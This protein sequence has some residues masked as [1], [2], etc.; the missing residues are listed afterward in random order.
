[1]A[2]WKSLPTSGRTFLRLTAGDRREF[3]LASLLLPT[4]ALAFRGLGFRRWQATLERWA[5]RSATV[6]SDADATAKGLRTAWLVR[7]AARF[8]AGRE[9]CLAQALVLW[10]LLRRRGFE[11]ELRIGVRKRGD[12][13]QAHAWVEYRDLVLNDRG[14]E[15]SPYLS[16]DRAIVSLESSSA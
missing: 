10:W 4:T 8:V 14:D 6:R 12:Q 16:F 1:M 15:L 13:L 11:S 5:P 3:V 7:T 2:W 9:S